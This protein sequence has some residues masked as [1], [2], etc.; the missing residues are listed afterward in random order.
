MKKQ[1]IFISFI[2]LLCFSIISA[3]TTENITNA[4]IETKVNVQVETDENGKVIS[5]KAISGQPMFREAAEKAALDVTLTPVIKDGKAVKDSHTVIIFDFAGSNL[6]NWFNLGMTLLTLE[7][8][9]T[10][11]YFDTGIV[12]YLIPQNWGA[13]QKLIQHLEELKN[14]ELKIDTSPKPPERVIDRSVIKNPD[15]TVTI[16]ETKTSTLSPEQKS[17]SEAIAIGQSLIASIRGR[18]GVEPVNL[19]YFNLGINVNM[20]LDKADSQKKA[21]RLQS[22]KPF[23]QFISNPQVE[24]PK[25]MLAELQKMAMLMEKGVFTDNDKIL[26]TEYLTKINTIISRR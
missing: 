15:G 11:R 1:F 12:S 23:Q 18:L 16:M 8:A 2:L 7:K 17:S 14:I 5:A 19:W 13:E 20:A 24:V 3:Q 21:E 22:V 9:P 10:L 25:V 4:D 6:T 26:L